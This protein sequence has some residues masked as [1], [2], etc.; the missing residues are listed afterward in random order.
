VLDL[1]KE[2]SI[3]ATPD[4]LVNAFNLEGNAVG[5]KGEV[6]NFDAVESL[7]KTFAGSKYFKAVTIDS[8]N[9]MKQGDGVEFDMRIILKR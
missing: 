4:L 8:T 2:I 3:L 5:I 1:L 6:Q 7:K 9:L